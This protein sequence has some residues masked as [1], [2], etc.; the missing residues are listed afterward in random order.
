V[1]S[2]IAA[3]AARSAFAD[4]R[5]IPDEVGNALL[6]LALPGTYKMIEAAMRSK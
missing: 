4:V 1:S 2:R 3:A 5:V 6:I